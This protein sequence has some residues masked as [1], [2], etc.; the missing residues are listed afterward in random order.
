MPIL[1]IVRTRKIKAYTEFRELVF[2]SHLVL[3][4][5]INVHCLWLESGFMCVSIFAQS[6]GDGGDP[7]QYAGDRFEFFRC[8]EAAS[9]CC[10]GFNGL[11]FACLQFP[12]LVGLRS[13]ESRSFGGFSGLF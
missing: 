10:I 5:V 2:G 3:H 1:V 8:H 11:R 9:H 13:C 6:Y 7:V 12:N 4:D